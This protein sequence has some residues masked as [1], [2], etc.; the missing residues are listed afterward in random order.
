VFAS[1]KRTVLRVPVGEN[2]ADLQLS[3]CVYRGRGVW[4]GMGPLSF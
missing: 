1:E 2:S 3:G 4:E